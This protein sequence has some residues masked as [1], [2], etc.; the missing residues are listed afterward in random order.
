MAVC[1]CLE[2]LK[3]FIDWRVDHL[4]SDLQKHIT[5]EKESMLL[6]QIS[7]LEDVLQYMKQEVRT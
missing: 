7:T 4:R 6:I 5:S 1:E 2:I 3:D